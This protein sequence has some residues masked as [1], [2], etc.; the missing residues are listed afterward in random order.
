MRDRAAILVMGLILGAALGV[1]AADQVRAIA[2][3]SLGY[4]LFMV[5]LLA[6][7]LLVVLGQDTLEVVYRAIGARFGRRPAAQTEREKEEDRPPV[8]PWGWPKV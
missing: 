1:V 5:G 6:L 7:G 2:S 3:G 4:L 8:N